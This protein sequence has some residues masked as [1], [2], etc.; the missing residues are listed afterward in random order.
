MTLRYD[1]LKLEYE[2]RDAQE[3]FEK[4]DWSIE[5]IKKTLLNGEFETEFEEWLQEEEDNGV[6]PLK[7][8]N[9]LNEEIN[10]FDDQIIE[11]I[12]DKDEREWV[13]FYTGELE[14]EDAYFQIYRLNTE[15]ENG[16]V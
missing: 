15:V 14:Q 13:F 5:D 1:K 7:L 2:P 6:T 9:Y 12:L 8:F 3:F 10:M 16:K 4:F 11:T